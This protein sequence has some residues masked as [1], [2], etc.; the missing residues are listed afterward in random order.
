MFVYQPALLMIG[1]WPDIIQAFVTSCIGIALFAGAL[2]GY[3]ITRAPYWQR[4]LLL[5]GGMCLVFPGVW[6]DIIGTVLAGIV[7]VYQLIE[8]AESKVIFWK[9]L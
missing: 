8:W 5:A 6:N 7:I 9:Q 2:H 1:T 4:A 3:F